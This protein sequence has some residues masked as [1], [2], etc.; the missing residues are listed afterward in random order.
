[1]DANDLELV[2]GSI[3]DYH[4]PSYDS[5][6]R[7]VVIMVLCLI[8]ALLF[9]S[10]CIQIY[11][12]TMVKD[13]LKQTELLNDLIN[14]EK[15][16]LLKTTVLT[17][18]ITD[19]NKQTETILSGIKRML[20]L[21]QDQLNTHQSILESNE[22][23]NKNVVN[24][25]K[26]SLG[27]MLLSHDDLYRD[28]GYLTPINYCPSD[29]FFC[30]MSRGSGSDDGYYKTQFSR[31]FFSGTP[32]GDYIQQWLNV[33]GYTVTLGLHATQDVLQLPSGKYI[34]MSN[35]RYEYFLDNSFTFTCLLS[36]LS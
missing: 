15:D 33:G 30:V 21:D 19:Q 22:M 24:S 16:Q 31:C 3:K 1:M 6:Y 10:V 13:Q 20:L 5:W 8:V 14:V 11:Q 36:T 25:H 12:L 26:A 2:E 32:N 7:N 27:M 35:S 9:T 34:N 4:P 18:L 29:P 17:Q 28:K 23:L